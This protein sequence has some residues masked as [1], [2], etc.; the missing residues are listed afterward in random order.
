MSHLKF[1][2]RASSLS[3]HRTTLYHPTGSALLTTEF[4]QNQ[5]I[6]DLTF[7]MNWDVSPALFEAL[8]GFK[9]SPQ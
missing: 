8:Y 9:R 5:K 6:K 4:P 7:N 2:G 3:L 1:P